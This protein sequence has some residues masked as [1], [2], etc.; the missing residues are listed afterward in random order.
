MDM[1]TPFDIEHKGETI[2]VIPRRIG[3]DHVYIIDFPSRRPPI[4]LTKATRQGGGHFWTTVP[5]E[6]DKKAQEKA[7]L[8]AGVIGGLIT[9]HYQKVNSLVQ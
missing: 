4:M 3:M 7:L 5:E 1:K 6:R 8:E 2:Q 9:A